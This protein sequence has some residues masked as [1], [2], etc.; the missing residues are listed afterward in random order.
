M[1]RGTVPAGLVP[2]VSGEQR[3]WEIGEVGRGKMDAEI[4][5]M[6]FRLLAG[7]VCLAVAILILAGQMDFLVLAR[8]LRL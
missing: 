4:D 6:F 3:L 8:W 1:R 7:P 5:R 2:R